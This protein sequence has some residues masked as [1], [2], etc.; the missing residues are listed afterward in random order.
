MSNQDRSRRQSPMLAMSLGAFKEAAAT[1][2]EFELRVRPM[3]DNEPALRPDAFGNLGA[4]VG[5]LVARHAA[6]LTSDQTALPSKCPGLRNKILHLKSQAH[7]RLQ[8]LGE[9]LDGAGVGMVDLTQIALTDLAT[10][11]VTNVQTETTTQ[12]GCLYGWMFTIAGSG[13][14]AQAVEV[15]GRA[16]Q[17]LEVVRDTRLARAK[18]A[19]EK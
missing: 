5:K 12:T 9:T 10:A 1:A 2:T 7:D 4:L 17:F 13:A 11:P 8:D 14:F 16:V 3:P 15:F 19:A 18:E 6:D